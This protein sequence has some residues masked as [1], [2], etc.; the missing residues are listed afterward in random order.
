MT[1]YELESYYYDLTN[2]YS[3]LVEILFF[4]RIVGFALIAFSLFFLIFKTISLLKS[5]ALM[6]IGLLLII[7]SFITDI[8]YKKK[9]EAVAERINAL[10]GRLTL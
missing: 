9:I 8:K 1:L 5:Y 10:K 2:Q 7:I 6:L 4:I 3:N